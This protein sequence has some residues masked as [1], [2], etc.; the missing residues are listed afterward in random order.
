M[1][2]LSYPQHPRTR[3]FLSFALS[4]L[5]LLSA[6]LAAVIPNDVTATAT[7]KTVDVFTNG[8]FEHGFVSQNGCGMVGY[9]WRCFTNGGAAGYGFYDDQWAPVVAAGEHSQLIEVNQKGII[10]GD[11]DRYAGV[12]QTVRV[13]DWETYALKLSGMIR[14]TNP[15]GDPYRYQVQVGWTAGPQ[16]DWSAVTNWQD[17]GW[18]AYYDRLAPGGFSAYETSLMAEDDYITVYVRVWKKWPKFD[19]EIDIN[20]DAISLT[21][22]SPYVARGWSNEQSRGDETVV[23]GAGYDKREPSVVVVEGGSQACVAE[24][25]DNGGFEAGFNPVFLGHVGKSWGFFTNGGNAGYGFYDEEWAPVVAEGGHGQL[26]ELNA[27]GIAAGDNDR[28]AGIY[29]HIRGLTPGQS[30]TLSLSGMMR[31]V[32]GG[33]DPY[34]FETQWGYNSG[35]DADWTHVTDWQGVDLGGIDART[36]PGEM[37]SYS[38]TFT[39]PASEMTLFIRG[40]MKWAMTGTEFDLNLD[41]ISVTGCGRPAPCF[42][43]VCGKKG[44]GLGMMEPLP[45]AGSPAEPGMGCG[46]TVRAGDSLGMIAQ[47]HG[48]DAWALQQANGIYDAN[49]IYVGQTLTLP[50]CG[51]AVHGP[52]PEKAMPARPEPAVTLVGPAEVY[53]VRAGDT[54]SAI[55][56]RYGADSGAVAL[57]NGIADPDVIYVGQEIVIP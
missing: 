24:Y 1:Q 42:Y 45:P 41:A 39:A 21:G 26:I 34:R 25:I 23:I 17:T 16:A 27:K 43:D 31:G 48:V 46:Y 4:A 44:H 28:Y 8:G 2:F 3:T 19:E 51:Q 33:D 29:Q 20:L 49:M 5:M 6:G 30:Y 32:G 40:W 56:E 50:G 47:R 9:G 53:V 57:H 7:S 11:G 36:E 55:C 12:Y 38:T 35:Y 15:D 52:E 13:V 18:Y 14:T 22:P 54:F 37:R 10:D